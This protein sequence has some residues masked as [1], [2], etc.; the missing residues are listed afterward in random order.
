MELYEH[1]DWPQ[2][3]VILTIKGEESPEEIVVLGGHGDSISGM[4]RQK[5]NKAPGADDNA[6][7]IAA[8]TEIIRTMV[9][10]QYRPKKTIKFMAY[11][12]EEV[13]LRGSMEI[14]R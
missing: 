7:G 6:S 10:G 12:A 13:G 9:E 11:A 2:P 1:K 4:F 3:S 5:T 14:A 8:L